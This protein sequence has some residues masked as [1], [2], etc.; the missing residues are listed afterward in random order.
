MQIHAEA[1]VVR[2]N[3]RNV[4]EADTGEQ[5]MPFHARGVMAPLRKPADIVMLRETVRCMREPVISDLA[6]EHMCIRVRPVAEA[7]SL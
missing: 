7:P 1:A 5:G 4:R 2:E 3:V 6:W